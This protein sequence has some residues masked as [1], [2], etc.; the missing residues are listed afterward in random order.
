MQDSLRKAFLED[1]AVLIKGLLTPTQ[2]ARCREAFDWAI[3]NHGPHAT[4]MLAGTAQQSHVDNANPRAKERLEALVASLPFGPLFADLWG[5]QNVWY[6]AEE[7]FLK[8]GGHGARTFWH[9]DT[10]YLPWAGDHWG[11]AWV[12][13]ESVPKR[14]AL[15]IVR[16]SHRGPRYDGTTFIDPNDPTQPLHGNGSLPRLPNI[17]AER[18]E[19]PQAY[20]ILSWATEPGDVVLLHPG[21]LHGGAPVDADFPDRHTFVF[22]FF[23]DDATFHP[24]PQPSR[25]GFPKQGFLFSEEL[26]TLNAGDPF[27]HTTFRQLV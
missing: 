4:R 16:G 5:S 7:V 21:S 6:F 22:R 19:N 3:E 24:L 23:G 10:A 26:A 11:N 2:L 9:Q 14:N 1:G 15:E 20:D 18:R 8:A 13:F 12:S 27:R 17:E 25:S